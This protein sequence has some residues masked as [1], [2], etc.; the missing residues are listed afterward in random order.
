VLHVAL[1]YNGFPGLLKISDGASPTVCMTCYNNIQKPLKQCVIKTHNYNNHNCENHLKNIHPEIWSTISKEGITK[2]TDKK[3][4][5]GQ[6]TLLQTGTNS[7][8]SKMSKEDVEAKVKELL[9]LFFNSANIAIRQSSNVHLRALLD[10][11]VDKGHLLK[12]NLSTRIYF[13]RYS[14][15][16][17][18]NCIFSNTVTTIMNMVSLSRAHYLKLTGHKEMPFLNISHDGWD[19]KRYDFLG[20]SLHFICPYNWHKISVPIGLQRLAEDKRAKNI[21]KQLGIMIGRYG[22]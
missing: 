12:N 4:P 11:L 13:T 5:K 18:E 20:A 7:S 3:I 22:N 2:P 6:T 10:L 15:K 17:E 21:A 14:Y 8:Q 9:Y 19:S 1:G 16:K